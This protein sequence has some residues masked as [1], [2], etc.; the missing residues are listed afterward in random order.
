MRYTILALLCLVVLEAARASTAG[1]GWS[2]ERYLRRIAPLVV[3]R[4]LSLDERAR[5]LSQGSRESLA[6]IIETWTRAPAFLDSVRRFTE[7]RLALSG[8]SGDID[9]DLPGNL[10]VHLES[11]NLP[12]SR[13]LTNDYCVD[14]AGNRRA[15]DTGA[16]FEAGIL[17]TRA[18]LAKHAGAFNLARAAHLLRTFTCED[19]PLAPDR[20]PPAAA[21]DYIDIFAATHSDLN[22]GFGNNCYACHGQFGKHAQL[23]VK[24][25]ATG[26]YV[27]S[28]TGLQNTGTDVAGGTSTQG[29]FVSHYRNPARAEDESSEIF[30]KPARDLAEAA[31]HVV[32]DDAFLQCTVKHVL[33]YYLRLRDTVADTVPDALLAQIAQR[34][35]TKQADPTMGTIIAQTLSH[36]DVFASYALHGIEEN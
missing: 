15:C 24:F 17:T 4:P 1:S 13:I 21:A 30:G 12:A 3:G 16:P 5:L 22:F 11:Q 34:I 35:Q 31:A 29:T 8:K 2:A 19:Y 6:V 26:R 33:K 27:P 7:R 25:D 18:Y 36:E 14:A 20:E 28:A 10:A 32:K 9:Y 23:F